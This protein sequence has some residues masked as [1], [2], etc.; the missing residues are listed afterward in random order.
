MLQRLRRD[1]L[2]QLVFRADIEAVSIGNFLYAT[3]KKKIGTDGMIG[4][5]LTF[6]LP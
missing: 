2:A 4:L 5:G 1:F 6:T 3:P